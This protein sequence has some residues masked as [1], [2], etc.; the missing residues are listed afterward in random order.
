MCIAPS[1]GCVFNSVHLV[2]LLTRSCRWSKSWLGPVAGERGLAQ[3]SLRMVPRKAP[4]WRFCDLVWW[5]PPP[6]PNAASLLLPQP[7]PRSLHS[8]VWFFYLL[9]MELGVLTVGHTAHPL[10]SFLPLLDLWWSFTCGGWPE[11]GS[12]KAEGGRFSRA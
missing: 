11:S 4:V 8:P 2:P 7:T 9:L 3:D 10:P 12:V 6:H 1:A 5:K